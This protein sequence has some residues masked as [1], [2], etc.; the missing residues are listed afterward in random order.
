[1]DYP[2]CSPDFALSGYRQPELFKK[3][4]IGKRCETDADVKQA[5][6][7]WLQFLDTD[8]FLVSRWDNCSNVSCD[9]EVWCV[10]SVARLPCIRPTQVKALGIIAWLL[11]HFFETAL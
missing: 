1:M 2:S 10:P 7:S 5:V 4:L 6:T 3:Q 8:F 9:L 11:P